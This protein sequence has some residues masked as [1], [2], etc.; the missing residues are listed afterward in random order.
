MPSQQELRQEFANFHGAGD[1]SP[2][3]R[4]GHRGILFN[5]H[6]REGT[7]TL[8]DYNMMPHRACETPG[9]QFIAGS[10]FEPRLDG[11]VCAQPTQLARFC[12]NYDYFNTFPRTTATASPSSSS[13]PP[14]LFPTPPHHTQRPKMDERVCDNPLIHTL[15]P[16]PKIERC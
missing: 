8:Y 13:P 9:W 4:E 1:S 10:R 6:P 16:G 12:S 11:S 14:P 5:A 15:L 7:R 3:L 2:T